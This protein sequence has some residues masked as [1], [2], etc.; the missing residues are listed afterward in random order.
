MS[1]FYIEGTE[2]RPKIALLGSV[3][4]KWPWFVACPQVL[5]VLLEFPAPQQ[6][7]LL[8]V[9]AKGG[10]SLGSPARVSVPQT[11]LSGCLGVGR[12]VL[13]EEN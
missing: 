3:E 9:F 6:S 12:G 11:A 5:I 1:P 4:T 10:P 2:S 7:W 8:E 13:K